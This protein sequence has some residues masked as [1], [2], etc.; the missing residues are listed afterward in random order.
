MSSVT[1]YSESKKIFGNLH[2]P[3][4]KAP[5]VVCL[6]GLESSKDSAKWITYA[7]RLYEE[8]YACLRFN[9]RGSGEGSEK[10]EGE[11]ED[12]SLTSRI[13]DYHSALD[14]LENNGKVDMNR[15]GAVGSSFG[16]MVALA[17]H[18]RNVKATVVLAS[19][20]KIPR[21]DRPLIPK[22][23][24]VYYILPS[25]RRFKKG[26]YEDL[27]KYDLIEDVKNTPPLLIIQGDADDTVPLEHAYKLYEAASEPKKLEI[28][29]GADHIFSQTEHLNKAINH[30]LTWYKKY[31]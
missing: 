2:L 22:E 20:Y 6:H 19:P 30:S 26:F 27:K 28:I 7:S 9:F 14:F 1:F 23:E 18:C 8:G 15:L 31:L 16:G 21:Y 24:G 11:F 17:T 12:I 4:K 25:G 10:S 29:K 13:K 5:C 3:Y